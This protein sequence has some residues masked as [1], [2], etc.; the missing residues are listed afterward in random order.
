M[1]TYRFPEVSTDTSLHTTRGPFIVLF[2]LKVEAV[3]A[4]DRADRVVASDRLLA[5]AARKD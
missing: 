5:A 2:S 1:S 4:S 3:V